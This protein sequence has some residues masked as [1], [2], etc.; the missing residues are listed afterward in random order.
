MDIERSEVKRVCEEAPEL[1]ESASDDV[2]T[3]RVGSDVPTDEPL[4]PPDIFRSISTRGRCL[5]QVPSSSLS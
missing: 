4:L 3:G 5:P 2:T 1:G